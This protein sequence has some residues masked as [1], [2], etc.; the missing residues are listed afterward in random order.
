MIA[1]ERIVL[2]PSSIILLN[3]LLALLI[4]CMIRT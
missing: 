3:G 4:N 1:G 2:M